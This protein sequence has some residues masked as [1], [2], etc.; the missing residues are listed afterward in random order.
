M[1]IL[2]GN[3]GVG[4]STFLTMLQTAIP[5]LSIIQEP[6]Q[7]WHT[8]GQ[9]DSLLK[10]F[11]KDPKRW[12]FTLETLTMIT[13]ALDYKK[14]N[15]TH[16]A[17]TIFE[18]SMYSGHYCFAKNGYFQGFFHEVEWNVYTAWAKFLLHNQ[19][20]KTPKGFIYLRAEPQTCFNRIQKRSRSGENL[21][22]LSYLEKIHILHDQF[23]IKKESIDQS[24]K[25]IPVLILNA[26]TDFQ[27]DQNHFK[28]LAD[29]VEQFISGNIAS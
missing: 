21:I 4:K 15:I 13:R 16:S 6:I 14:E 28:N 26:D 7:A 3:V 9:K 29:T 5:S 8:Q 19:S 10:N 23:L 18:R 22:E 25:N 17:I 2:E 1:Y 11:Y 20:N 12:A 24:L 27:E